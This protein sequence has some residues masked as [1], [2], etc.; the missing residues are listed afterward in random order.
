MMATKRSLGYLFAVL[1]AQNS[2]M[3]SFLYGVSVLKHTW[4]PGLF[5]ACGVPCREPPAIPLAPHGEF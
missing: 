2:N 1:L 4:P 5:S 3:F